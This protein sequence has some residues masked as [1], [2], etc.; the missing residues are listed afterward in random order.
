[1][2]LKCTTGG[3]GV[4]CYYKIINF[5]ECLCFFFVLFATRGCHVIPEWLPGFLVAS[6]LSQSAFLFSSCIVSAFWPY[7]DFKTSP[8][9]VLEQVVSLFETMHMKAISVFVSVFLCCHVQFIPSESSISNKA[10]FSNTKR[11]RVHVNRWV[12]IQNLTCCW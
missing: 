5:T 1:M 9:A 10:N 11:L 3:M 2:V 6:Q 7:F 4:H 8:S 12:L